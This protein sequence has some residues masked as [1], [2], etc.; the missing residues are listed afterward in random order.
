MAG[1]PASGLA[2]ACS[3]LVNAISSRLLSTMIT[4]AN[5]PEFALL[6]AASLWQYRVHLAGKSSTMRVLGGS[7]YNE[8]P[9]AR[10]LTVGH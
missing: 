1:Q 10:T 6:F 5:E 2:A 9:R 8:W 4:Q 3:R 7:T